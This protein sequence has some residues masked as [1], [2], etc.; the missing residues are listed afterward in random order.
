MIPMRTLLSV[1]L[2]AALAG[3]SL[4]PT[5]ER[6]DAPVSAAYPAGAAYKP[7]AVNPAGV[8][9]ADVGWRD[10]FT[11]PLLQRL[12]E[13]SLAN[14]RDLR[15]AALNVEAARAQYR[16]QRSNLMPSIGLAGKETAQ[17]TPGSLTPSGEATTSHNYQVGAALSTWELDLFGRIR[18]LSDKALESYLALDETRT[19]T[20][21]SLVAEV[22]NAYLTLRA[23]QELLAL[24]R[25]T[26][27]SQQDS[28]KLT[29]QS[30]DIGLSTA[31]DLS[32]AEVGLRTAERNLSQYTRQAAQDRNA[33]VLLAG[34][35][36]PDDLSA[37][38]DQAVRLDDGMLPTALPAGLPSDLLARRPDI[39]AAE[40]QLKGANANI[41]A[42]RAAFF[43]TISLTG[44]AGTASSSLG[45]LFDG[46][47]GAWS[48]TPQITVPI[49]AGG[50]LLAGLDLAHVQK[51]VQIAQYEK[52]IQSGFREVADALAGRGTLDEQI[53]AQRLLVDASQR[54]YDVS[55][56]RFRQGIDNYLS[57][58][59][60]QRSLYSAQQS[61]VDT[62]R[63]RLSNLVNLYK[64]LGGGWTERTASA[65]GATQ[66][67][68]A[69]GG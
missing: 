40:H 65:A 48:F 18:S 62:R 44:T 49:F 16:I 27:K 46:G 17:R 13:M 29:Q 64:A 22:A 55:D 33:L 56:Q 53:Q 38:L 32:Q 52:A 31:L 43:P 67:A 11:D 30:Y 37:A 63:A 39:R 34:Q 57:V 6:P 8:A 14:N 59:D 5:Y 3:C 1:S 50:S 54:A 42:A 60:S 41:G 47:S 68:Q 35:P 9:T 15:V 12:I 28:F 36:L 45:G 23:D 66:P 21:L 69:A 58:L 26:L 4:A 10:F 20:Q 24:T 61:L 25:D 19:A 51:N 2:A 7:D